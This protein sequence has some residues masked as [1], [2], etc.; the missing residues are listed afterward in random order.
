[1]PDVPEVS[2]LISE[3]R[4]IS[5]CKRWG[6]LIFSSSM[7]ELGISERPHVE[8]QIKNHAIFTKKNQGILNY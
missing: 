2:D 4:L 6:F 3:I 7:T 5:Y 8:N 1:M